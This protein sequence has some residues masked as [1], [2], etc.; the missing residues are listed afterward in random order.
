MDLPP[1]K[2][3]YSPLSVIPLSLVLAYV[4]ILIHSLSSLAPLTLPRVVS[5]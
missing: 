3:F 5:K 1:G 2:A 4:H